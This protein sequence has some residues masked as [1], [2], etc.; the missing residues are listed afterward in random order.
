MAQ[1]RFYSVNIK[2]GDGE[3]SDIVSQFVRR[4][5]LRLDKPED[6]IIYQED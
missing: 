4:L 5:L 2:K 1:L 3:G 6:H